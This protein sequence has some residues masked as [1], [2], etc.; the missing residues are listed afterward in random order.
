[1]AAPLAVTHAA[2]PDKPIR[3]LVNFAPGGPLDQEARVI[4][5]QA[6]KLLGQTVVVENRSGASGNIGAQ[7][8]AQAA[9]DGYTL[10]M[11]VDTVFT[12][13]P[14]VF[15]KTEPDV[16][17]MRALSLA[18]TFNLA[19]AVR[20]ELGV[21]TLSEFLAYARTHPVT[22]SSAGHA[23]PGN[24]TFEKLNL[25]TGIKATHVPYRGNAPATHALLSGEVDAG[26]LAVPGMLPHVQAGKLQPL[27]V[28]GGDGDAG[29]PST[30]PIR[31]AGQPGLDNYDVR[32]GFVIMAPAGLP[33]AIAQVWEDVLGRIY[34]RPD[35]LQHLAA[36]GIHP[37]FSDAETARKWIQA[38]TQIWST[39]IDQAHIRAN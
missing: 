39:V 32:F 3:L 12:V 26:F 13:N 28:S 30:P 7:A 16:S 21:K 2:Y 14:L 19:L 29:L 18:G 20:P 34:A 33:D 5:Q 27:A 25:A 1:L 22:Y 8:A 9:P 6:G 35:F 36:Q 37:P 15:S 10:L 11:S 31:Q 4:A 23:S 17:A 24:L 38:Q